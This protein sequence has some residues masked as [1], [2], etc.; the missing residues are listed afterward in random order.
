MK[1]FIS[2]INQRNVNIIEY[3]SKCLAFYQANNIRHAQ[4]AVLVNLGLIQLNINNYDFALEDLYK[5]LDLYEALERENEITIDNQIGIIWLN[6]GS[7]H[8]KIGNHQQALKDN[9]KALRVFQA[10][11]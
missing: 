5:A 11:E 3:F 9:Q 6:I 4:A 8:L 1:Y 10:R 7:A 2:E